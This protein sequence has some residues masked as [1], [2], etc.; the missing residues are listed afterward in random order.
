[1]SSYD[2]LT[3]KEQKLLN[4]L[5]VCAINKE[6]CPSPVLIEKSIGKNISLDALAAKG[7][8]T[9]DYYDTSWKVV[10]LL[11]GEH[12]GLTTDATPRDKPGA[13]LTRTINHRGDTATV[14]SHH[15]Q[16]IKDVSVSREI[17]PWEKNKGSH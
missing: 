12:K 4:M 11:T 15:R 13:R 16:A 2:K 6:R 9:I 14:K 3:E 8:C 17:P 10:T 1:M 7:Y 5:T